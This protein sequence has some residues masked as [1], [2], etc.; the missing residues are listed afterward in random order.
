[1]DKN[2]LEQAVNEG[3]SAYKIADRFG[4][5]ASTIRYWLRKHGL[6]TMRAAGL[7]KVYLCQYCGGVI[8][9]AKR[10]RKYCSWSCATRAHQEVKWAK[11]D[12]QEYLIGCHP[13]IKRYLIDRRGHEC[14]ICGLSEWRQQPIALILD[15]IDGN[16]D[17]NHRDNLRLVC[18]NCDAQLPTYKGRN[19]GNGRYFRRQRYHDGK[20]Y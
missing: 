5:G 13:T 1:M 10:E 19:K 4:K 17:D 15:H 14:E 16:S 2:E 3:L 8:T 18:P 7:H 6:R 9:A 12:K 11:M 20:S